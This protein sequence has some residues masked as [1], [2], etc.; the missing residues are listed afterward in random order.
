[1]AVTTDPKDVQPG[2]FGAGGVEHPVE[3]TQDNKE[4]KK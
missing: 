2:G 4:G 1:M 3:P